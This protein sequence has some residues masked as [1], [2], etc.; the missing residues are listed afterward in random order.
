MTSYSDEEYKKAHV[1]VLEI[2]KNISQADRNK[3]PK[4]YIYYCIED[5]DSEYKFSYDLNKKFEEQRIMELT[6]ILIANLYIKYWATEERRD[7]IKCNLQNELYDNNKKNNELYRY[8]KLFP[9]NNRQISVESNE[10]SLIIIKEN[11][12]NKI[13]RRIKKILKLT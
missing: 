11:F 6:Q 3:I 4:E 13:I 10:K 9:Q 8:D 2:L 12:I 5:S 7:E 1:E